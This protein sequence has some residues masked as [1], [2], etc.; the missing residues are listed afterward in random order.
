MGH[1]NGYVRM[2]L[3]WSLAPGETVVAAAGDADAKQI[4]LSK[5]TTTTIVALGNIVPPSTPTEPSSASVHCERAALHP[6]LPRVK[7]TEFTQFSLNCTLN[8]Y[9]G[10]ADEDYHLV[11]S[12][13]RSNDGVVLSARIASEG[14]EGRRGSYAHC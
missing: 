2:A 3:G 8:Q 11:L 9:K 13:L 12:R 6:T 4:D 7:P 14:F 5:H 1:Q 10:E